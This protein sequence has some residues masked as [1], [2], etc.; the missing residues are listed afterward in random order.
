MKI[1]TDTLDDTSLIRLR[2]TTKKILGMFVLLCALIACRYI[3][4]IIQT[5]PFHEIKEK[6]VAIPP[7]RL[8]IAVLLVV[9]TYLVMT[10]YDTLGLRL[11]GSRLPYRQIAFVS[12]IGD[13][14]NAN[15]AFSSFVGSAVKLR[16]YL[17]RGESVTVVARAI[18]AYTVAY[19]AGF[20]LLFS[21]SGIA[22]VIIPGCSES[23]LHSPVYAVI[24]VAASIV[25]ILYLTACLSGRVRKVLPAFVPQGDIGLKLLTV[26][27]SDWSCSALI[28]FLLIPGAGIGRFPAFVNLYLFSHAL[29]MISQSPGGFGVFESICLLMSR[30]ISHSAMLGSLFTFRLLFFI[31]PLCSALA[32]LGMSK[33]RKLFVHRC[34]GCLPDNGLERFPA[35]P[36]HDLPFVSVVVPAH[37]EERF[38]PACLAALSGQ[39][40]RGDYEIIVVDNA[41]TDATSGIARRYGCGVLS[42]PVKGYNRAVKKGFEAAEGEIIACTDADTIVGVEWLSKLVSTLS[43]RGV[44]AC[45]GLFTFHDGPFWLKLT[46]L[47]FGKFNYHISGANMAVWRHAY[48]RSGGFSL[49]VNLGADVEIGKRLKR[50]GDVVIDRSLVVATSSRRFA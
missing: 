12:F 5:T 26:A 2:I 41:S 9:V 22:S 46:A 42:E 27:I 15:M 13:T 11:A 32:L 24:A 8:F 4:S 17:A 34:P 43:R 39:D 29:G 40:Y 50:I 19:W 18:A 10:G 44:V 3:W 7:M 38:L 35:A 21:L 25:T 1:I 28:F 30:N 20:S 16:F 36:S 48:H 45:G 33:A 47:F 14:I 37:N 6:I 49:D 23:T 31:F